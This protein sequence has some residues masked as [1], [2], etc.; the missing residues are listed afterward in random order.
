LRVVGGALKEVIHTYEK[1]IPNVQVEGD[2]TILTR[3]GHFC[4]CNMK[5]KVGSSMDCAMAH[6]ELF[7]DTMLNF[8]AYLMNMWFISI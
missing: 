6:Q 7:S 2:K 3:G 8:N 1:I 5:V 4:S